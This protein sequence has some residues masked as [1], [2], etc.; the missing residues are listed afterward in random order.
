MR[1]GPDDPTC[2]P[3]FYSPTY[4]HFG[5]IPRRPTTSDANDIIWWNP[6]SRDFVSP[7][8][9]RTLTRGL[10]K[11]SQT[12]TT[13]IIDVVQGLLHRCKWYSQSFEGPE[14]ESEATRIIK[15]LVDSLSL[16][17]ERLRSIPATYERMVLGVTNI[18]RAY[19]ELYGL[20]EY[21]TVYR[22]WMCSPDRRG[23]QPD[24][25]IGDKI[26]VFTFD[27]TV[28]QLYYRARLPC[29]FIRPLTPETLNDVKILRVV[30]PH[31]P[32]ESLELAVVEGFD[33]IPAGLT[34][35]QRMESLHA[36]TRTLPWYRNPF[37][38]GQTAQPMDVS[39]VSGSHSGRKGR[40]NNTPTSRIQPCELCYS[41]SP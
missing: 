3:Q 33:P 9:Q 18:Q 19:L 1:W 11:L 41:H 40:S 25:E 31:D 4:C 29:W 36:R 32:G 12:K 24:A 35:E 38:L 13:A 5:T 2:W 22:P 26:G 28:A 39:S 27:P 17:L 14:K 15:L 8:S 7:E 20:L 23:G 34:L 37:K 21:M 6:T 30:A 10:G 16:A